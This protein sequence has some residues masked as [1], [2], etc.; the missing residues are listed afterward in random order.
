[1][2]NLRRTCAASGV[3]LLT[4]LSGCGGTGDDGDSVG[5]GN[6]AGDTRTVTDAAGL[7][8]VVPADPGDVVVLHYAGTQA[9]VD[10]GITPVAQGS[11][12]ERE[13]VP[14]DVW[15]VI[16]DVPDVTEAGGDPQVEQIANTA[17]DLI[18]A[19]NVLDDD[20]LSQLND[21]APVY[22]FT[23]WGEDRGDFTN[24]VA[25]IAE[26]LDREDEYRQLEEDLQTRSDE[27]AEEHSDVIEGL[28]A[29]AV[30]SY[31]EGNAYLNG[32]GS[33]TENLLGGLGFAWSSSTDAMLEGEE[34]PEGNVSLEQLGEAASDADVVFFDSTYDGAP[35]SLAAGLVSSEAFERLPA[36]QAGNDYPFGKM[37]IA[38]FADADASLDLIVEA[39]RDLAD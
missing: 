24:R 28:T 31:E 2:R 38:G 27:I 26:V 15:D 36:V 10:L 8:V 1:M 25:E 37:T 6:D 23:L 17:P 12:P 35:L 14:D 39:L 21:V 32:T 18:L 5:G 20:V 3:L 19:P 33:M 29:V 7:E 11:L 13:S 34:D 9:M 4:L 22:Q 30:S 16:E